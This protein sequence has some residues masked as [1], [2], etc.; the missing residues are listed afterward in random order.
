MKKYFVL[1]IVI[2]L[3]SFAGLATATVAIEDNDGYVGEAT[4]IYVSGQDVIFDGS[5]ATI[6]ANGHKKGV[7]TNTTDETNLTS[8]QLAYGVII[9]TGVTTSKSVAIANGTDG[10]MITFIM[11]EY[12]DADFIITDDQV[13][14]TSMTT[15]GWDDITLNLEGDRVTLLYVDDTYGWIII[16]QDTVT[17]AQ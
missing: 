1:A 9:V 17:I 15:T 10:Q 2:A 7:T 13:L 8:A 12:N 14:S 11:T 3:L 16:G 5:K 6:L 4:S